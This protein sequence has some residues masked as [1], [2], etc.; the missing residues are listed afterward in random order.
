MTYEKCQAGIILHRRLLVLCMFKSFTRHARK[1]TCFD[2][3]YAVRNSN[4]MLNNGFLLAC[5][6][7]NLTGCVPGELLRIYRGFSFALKVSV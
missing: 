5:Q 6:N 4:C 3:K 2:E 1:Q 7:I